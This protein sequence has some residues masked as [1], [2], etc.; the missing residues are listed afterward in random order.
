MP[1]K[2][3][4]N[5]QE[6]RKVSL[7]QDKTNYPELWMEV[8]IAGDKSEE[9]AFA[10][11]FA[12]AACTR[13]NSPDE[14]DLVVFTGGADVNPALYGEEPHS[15]THWSES[16]DKQDILL[17]EHC[18]KNGIPMFGVCRGAQFGH[19]MKGG[20]LYQD[21]DNHYG[22]HSMWDVKSRFLVSNV[23]SVHH[24]MVRPGNKG[25]DILADSHA[26]SVR[27]LNP[28]QKV[29]GMLEDIEAFF[30]RDV[31]F[32]GVQ[33]HPEYRGFE[34]FTK[35][36]LDRLNEYVIENPDV[37]LIGNVRRIKESLRVSSEVTKVLKE[38]A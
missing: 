4:L 6:E 16:R 11:M 38:L 37:E 33:G 22:E 25:M 19:V 23:S 13:A 15:S 17:W 20:K 31:C 8:F 7:Y 18:V 28:T 26:A 24:Q 30:Y 14:A 27:Y 35:W 1:R 5:A 29:S 34:N 36:C 12:Q 2:I 3:K 21:V 10:Q 9:V 32:L